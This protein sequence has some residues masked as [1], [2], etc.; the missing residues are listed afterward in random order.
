[1]VLLSMVVWQCVCVALL[2]ETL[3]GSEPPLHNS[4]WGAVQ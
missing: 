2:D 4:D 1:M 3:V